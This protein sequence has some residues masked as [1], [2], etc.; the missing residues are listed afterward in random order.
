VV[1]FGDCDFATDARL[2]PR[3]RYAVPANRTLLINAVSWAVRRDLIAIDP[4]TLETERV[5]LRP[6]DAELAF[7]STVVA[8]PLVVLGL[9]VGVWWTRRR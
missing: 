9:A 1:M 2:N 3:S 6:Q 7:W 5:T 8:L 4:K